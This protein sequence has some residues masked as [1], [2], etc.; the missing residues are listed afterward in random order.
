[1]SIKII[2][3]DSDDCARLDGLVE[4]STKKTYNL[5]GAKYYAKK[6]CEGGIPLLAEYEEV[7]K[8]GRRV[9]RYLPL[10]QFTD[11]RAIQRRIDN[12]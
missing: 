10:R 1:M 9:K 5:S 7:S 2:N 6:N 4:C 8:S 3:S 11:P 12:Q